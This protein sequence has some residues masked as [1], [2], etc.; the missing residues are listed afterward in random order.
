MSR[1]FITIDELIRQL[2]RDRRQVEKLVSRGR[3]PGRRVAG[4][5]RFNRTEITHWLETELRKL[6][7]SALAHVEQTHQSSSLDPQSPIAQLISHETVQVPLDAGTKP[8]V[9]QSLVEVAGRTWHVLEPSA[10][11]EAVRQR[12]T[13]MSTGFD[14]GMA[15]PHPRNPLPDAISESLVAFGRTLSGI[16]FGAP[17]RQLSDMFFLVLARDARTHLQILARLGRLMQTPGFVDELRAAET[18]VDA[19]AVICEA[20]EAIGN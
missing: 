14:N 3:I 12:E 17:R 2:G 5:W 19:H 4:E 15:I 13:V 6:D 16:P 7:D 1:D 9:L 8:S 11:L 18:S 10:V 20:D